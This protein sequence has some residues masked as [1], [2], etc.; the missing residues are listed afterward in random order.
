MKRI[1]INGKSM[2]WRIILWRI[3][4]KVVRIYTKNI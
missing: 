4:R 1:R 3:R 2:F